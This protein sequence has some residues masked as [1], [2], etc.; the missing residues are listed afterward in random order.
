[1]TTGRVRVKFCNGEIF[2]GFHRNQTV[3]LFWLFISQWVMPHQRSYLWLCVCVSSKTVLG[4]YSFILT[5]ISGTYDQHILLPSIPLFVSGTLSRSLCQWDASGI[6]SLVFRGWDD[7][8]CSACVCVD[9][10]IRLFILF[11]WMLKKHITCIHYL[12]PAVLMQYVQI[13]LIIY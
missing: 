4:F 8:R 13:I 10:D 11:Y 2:K 6:G 12:G 1:M 9:A 3:V 7:V 5:L